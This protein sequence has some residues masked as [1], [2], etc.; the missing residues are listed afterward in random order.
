MNG[1]LAGVAL[2][3][4]ALAVF[5]CMDTILKLLTAHFAVAQLMFARFFF[6]VLVLG[7]VIR[8]VTGHL[9]DGES[10]LAG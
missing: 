3:L 10:W 1:R 6:H 7:L 4:A 5:V 2:Q 9:P 8:L